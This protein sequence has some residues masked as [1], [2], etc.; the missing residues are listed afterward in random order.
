MGGRSIYRKTR[1]FRFD[2]RAPIPL[3]CAGS[4]PSMA[5]KRPKP[6]LNKG[7]KPPTRRARARP[8]PLAVSLIAL[9]LAIRLWGLGERLPDPT[10]GVNVLD[11]SAVEETDR[12]TMGRAWTMWGGGT[13]ALDLNP[14]T[15][16]WPGFSFY[17]GLAVQLGYKAYYSLSH[18]GA[19][20]AAFS[21]HISQGSNHMFLFGRLLSVLIGAWT[22][23]LAFRLVAR[24]GGRTAGLI[25]G[26]LIAFNP[27]HIM[28]SQ[29]IADPNLLALLFVLLAALALTRVAEKKALRDSIIAGAMIGLAGASKYVPLVLVV[30]LAL[31]HGR[32]F[33]RSRAFYLALLAVAVAMF[34]GSPFTFLDWKTT[35]VDMTT[36]RRALFSDW[37]GQTSF[38]FSLPTYLVVSLPHAMGWPAYLLALVGMWL[39]WQRLPAARPAFL[40]PVVMVLANG[41]LKAAQERY[42]LVAMPVLAFGTASA[43]L[44]GTEWLRKRGG[45][46]AR[47]VTAAPILIGALALTWPLPEYFAFRREMSKP[48]TRHLARAWINKNIPADRPMAVELYG[49]IF[50]PPER[51]MLIWPFFATQVPLVRS[52]YNAE[53][54]DGLDYYVLSR[55]VARRFEADSTGYPVESAYYR[56]I[57]AHAPIVWKTD[58]RTSS[59]PQIEVR[60]VPPGISTQAQRDSLF[61][62]LMPT[63]STVSRVALWCLDYATVFGRLSEYD[64]AIEWAMRGLK[65]DATRL[66]GRLHSV[67][68]YAYLNLRQFE[69]AEASATAG[70]ALSPQD[71]NLR[72]YRAM[73]LQESGRLEESLEEYVEAYGVAGDHRVLLNVAGAL[74]SMGRYE[75]AVRTLDRVPPNHPDRGTARQDMAVILLN[76]LHRNTEGIA[77]LREAASLA[78]DPAQARLL[79]DEIARLEG[80]MKKAGG[81]AGARP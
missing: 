19:T 76:Q 3:N 47:A 23:F 20:A 49:P 39:L 14:H 37:V 10:L 56:W 15:G 36:Q 75:D 32:D 48:D 42:M 41:A 30:P 57:R 79:R 51:T 13:K 65:V 4:G 22:I 72:L 11:D 24:L 81:A 70:I 8:D 69:F 52:A 63:P 45:L 46:P 44:Y 7:G 34:M 53:F 73:A 71:Q 40:I 27:L 38:P 62:V 12:T 43:I 9:A 78:R 28:T 59:G 16:G 25:A 74:T 77:A 55:E 80:Q 54:L 68:A 1:G 29:H 64:R 2:S 35:L 17:V 67:L 33:L 31:A 61:A 21:A 60:R 5:K 50:Q 58:A 18:P 66:N 6:P 26:L